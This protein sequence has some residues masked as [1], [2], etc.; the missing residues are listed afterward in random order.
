MGW[1]DVTTLWDN[2]YDKDK[3]PSTYKDNVEDTVNNVDKD[4]GETDMQADTR[5]WSYIVS[6]GVVVGK[7]VQ[8]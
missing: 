4:N 5:T 6:R 1:D 2:S 3:L 7:N 8:P